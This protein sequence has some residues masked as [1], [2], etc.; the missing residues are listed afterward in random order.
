M[1]I[2][3]LVKSEFRQGFASRLL[4]KKRPN[5][6]LG[7]MEKWVLEYCADLRASTFIGQ[8]EA[9]PTLFCN[10]HPA[11]ENLEISLRDPDHVTA[12]A[13]TSTVG[14]GDHIFVCDVLHKL[15]ERF[16]L[17]WEEPSDDFRDETGYFHS[18]DRQQVFVEMKAWLKGVANMFFD[19]TLKGQGHPVRLAMPLDVGFSWDARSITPLGPR[20]ADWLKRVA[21]NPDNGTDFFAWWNP[22]LDAE[23]FRRRALV[24][25]WSE[26]RWRPPINDTEKD[27]LSYVADSLET[28]YKLDS[29][30]EYPWAEWAAILGYLQ[31]SVNE[32]PFPRELATTTPSIGYRRHDVTVQLP[33]N[34]WITLP[35]SFSNF[36]PDKNH[37]YCAL[38]PPREVWATSYR[39]KGD[40]HKPLQ[41]QRDLNSR[42]GA[43]VG[44][45]GKRL[46]RLGRDTRTIRR[47]PTVFCLDIIQRRSGEPGHLYHHLYKPGRARLGNSGV[48]VIAC[49]VVCARF[50]GF[51]R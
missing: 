49:T 48:E 11:A 4:G 21:E 13:N 47:R 50:M 38:D 30:L 18:E 29:G 51:S 19:G 41:S 45:R 1:S 35:G 32:Y 6:V 42:E 23:Y 44:S 37:N 9:K 20:D 2:G 5:R 24:K 12:S 46:R 22:V 10:L 17:Q 3:L 16:H 15:G 40:L 8:R 34:W 39:F 14:P 28:A 36:K 43:R 25:I 7:E 26:V 31:R 27:V 33:G